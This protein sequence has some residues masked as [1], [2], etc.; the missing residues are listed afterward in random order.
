[1]KNLLSIITYYYY[2]SYCYLNSCSPISGYEPLYQPKKWNKYPEHYLFNCLAYA[3]NNYNTGLINICKNKDI[4]KN[5]NPQPGHYCGI[6]NKLYSCSNTESKLLCDN[7]GI[8]K[9]DFETKCPDNYYKI[10]LST[11]TDGAY[12]FYRQNTYGLWDHKDGGHKVNFYDSE[13]KVIINPEL[14]K[15][16]FS[17]Y[18]NY[19]NWCGYYCVPNNDFIKT[20]IS[21]IYDNKLLY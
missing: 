3:L 20:N 14:S 12:H 16:Q 5:V 13:N 10:G 21:R 19:D 4:C 8:I 15:R 2:Q 9:S 7:P 18:R 11:Q 17:K 6:E 1:M